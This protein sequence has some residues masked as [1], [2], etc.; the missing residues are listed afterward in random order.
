[1]KKL[2]LASVAFV[3]LVVTGPAVAADM[4]PVYKAPP[5]VAVYSWTGFYVGANLGYSWGRSSNDWDFFAPNFF[6]LPDRGLFRV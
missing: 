6:V 3:A 2:F 1:M 5:P 4:R